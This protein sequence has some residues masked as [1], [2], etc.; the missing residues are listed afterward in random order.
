[1][2]TAP[3]RTGTRMPVTW[4]AIA[5]S[6]R[7][8]Q[9]GA[10]RAQEAEQAHEGA[11]SSRLRPSRLVRGH[12]FVGYGSC[13]RPC[14]TSPRGAI[15]RSSTRSASVRD[16]RRAPR[17]PRG[18][19]PSP[20]GVHARR[21]GRVVAR[22]APRRHRAR[23]SSS[24]ISASTSACTRGS[25]QPTSCRSSRSRATPW[26]S[27]PRR[28]RSAR[29]P[30]RRRARA[31]RL[32]LRGGGLRAATGLLPARRARRAPPARRGRGARTGCR[33]A[34][35]STRARGRCWSAP[36]DA[37]VA[38]NLELATDDVEVASAIAR[39]GARVERRHARRPGDRPAPSRIRAR[40]GE[41]ERHRH[42]AGAPARARRAR[43][44]RGGARGGSR[45]RAASSSGSSPSACCG[46][47]QTAGVEL[48]G[49]DESRVLERALD[50]H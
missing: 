29:R 44:R 24:S 42:R 40:P 38:Y 39:R 28:P 27:P 35:S 33:P 23:P 34:S 12:G 22:L 41:H 46:S 4:D 6:G 10:V 20:L 25:A 18:R 5:S 16:E 14:P 43:A 26:S 50:R 17:R 30:D 15:R 9:R 11:R 31:T 3:V 19:R 49:V 7:D 13:S 45:S 36:A 32:P 48:P 1:M 37:L 8:G 21:G 2:I 47:G